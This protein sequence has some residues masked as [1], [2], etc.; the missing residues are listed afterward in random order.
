MDLHFGFK[1]KSFANNGAGRRIRPLVEKAGVGQESKHCSML[2][3]VVGSVEQDNVGWHLEAKSEENVY[4]RIEING[5]SGPEPPLD[6]TPNEYDKFSQNSG[7][8][9][10]VTVTYAISDVPELRICRRSTELGR[11]MTE[12]VDGG[13]IEG[14]APA[15]VHAHAASLL[16][17]GRTRLPATDC[18]A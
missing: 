4:F 7:D 17:A 18:R 10:L 11:W 8:Y 5:L 13:E 16:P 9:R 15:T 12:G 6:L 14:Q 2:C 3:C 1:Q